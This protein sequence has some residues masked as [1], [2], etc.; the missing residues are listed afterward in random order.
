MPGKED[1]YNYAEQIRK[2]MIEEMD[3]KIMSGRDWYDAAPMPDKIWVSPTEQETIDA[4]A[5][6][7]KFT[8]QITD[9]MRNEKNRIDPVEKLRREMREELTD[10]KNAIR[11]IGVMLDGDAPSDEALAKHKTLREAYKKYKMIE[12]L[13]LGQ[14]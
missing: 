13:I 7:E 14:Q 5:Q 10:I 9:M 4:E 6:N 12:A 2:Q 11:K 8:K 3:N 1:M